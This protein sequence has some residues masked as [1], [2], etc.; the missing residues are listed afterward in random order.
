MPGPGENATVYRVRFAGH[1]CWE[2]F[3]EPSAEPVASFR[4]RNAALTHALRLARGRV[5]L[6]PLLDRLGRGNAALESARCT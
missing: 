2:V 5:S 1:D 4:D 3:R 6:A